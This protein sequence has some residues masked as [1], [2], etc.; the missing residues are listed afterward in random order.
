MVLKIKDIKWH[1]A[2]LDDVDYNKKHGTDSLGITES[3]HRIIDF[4]KSA[5][6]ES[7]I[8]HELMHAYISSCCIASMGELTDIDMEEICAEIVGDH[9]KQ[10]VQRSARI[11]KKLKHIKEP[12][13]KNE[14]V[15]K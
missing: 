9:G 11:Y 4:K 1:L 5:F 6:S 12:K 13:K 2:L 14:E 8:R 7:L 15:L 10:I 3:E